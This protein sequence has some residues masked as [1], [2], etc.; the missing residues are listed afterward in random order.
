MTGVTAL[1]AAI[2]AGAVSYGAAVRA[3]R[4]LHPD[5]ADRL[6]A[7]CRIFPKGLRLSAE[8]A[9]TLLAP[10]R[11]APAGFVTAGEGGAGDA[12]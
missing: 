10:Y 12:D 9:I 7:M 4:A 8:H 2:A 3:L 5:D 11:I 6:R 1:A